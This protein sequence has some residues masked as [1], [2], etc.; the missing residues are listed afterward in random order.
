MIFVRKKVIIATSFNCNSTADIST[1]NGI[2]DKLVYLSPK[3]QLLYATDIAGDKPSHVQ[4][5]LACFLAGLLALGVATIPKKD[6]PPAHAWAAEGL[7]NT[8]Y[9]SYVESLTGLGPERISFQDR[10]PAQPTAGK[11]WSESL[12][13]WERTGK[14]GG[15][16][17]GVKLPAIVG[18]DKVG[19]QEREY[20]VSDSYSPLRPE[21]SDLSISFLFCSFG[22]C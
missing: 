14:Q 10:T 2:L 15:V 11:P 4:E 6:L 3:R 9:L 18:K 8:C 22:V 16:P 12:K 7:G 13:E 21:V 17:P 20:R 5:H 19:T 1:A